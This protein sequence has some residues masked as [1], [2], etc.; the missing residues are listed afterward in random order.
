Q[1]AERRPGH[2]RPPAARRARFFRVCFVERWRADH[3]GRAMA[4]GAQRGGLAGKFRA[5]WS[6]T[7]AR[8][9]ARH[10]RR[11]NPPDHDLALASSA[12][13]DDTLSALRRQGA[14]RVGRARRRS[15]ACGHGRRA[16][17][18][19]AEAPGGVMAKQTKTVGTGITARVVTSY[20]GD[21][22]VEAFVR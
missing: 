5:A 3:A 2:H 4:Q 21:D 22:A 18:A 7:F 19:E 16:R 17:P 20:D 9:L 15:D 8:D 14:R 13:H 12:K 6:A 10:W 1:P 11:R